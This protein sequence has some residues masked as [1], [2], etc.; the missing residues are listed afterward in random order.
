[1][2]KKASSGSLKLQKP[3]LYHIQLNYFKTLQDEGNI[4]D[5]HHLDNGTVFTRSH[6]SKATIMKMQRVLE[7]SLL[8]ELTVALKVLSDQKQTQISHFQILQLRHTENT[9]AVI[10]ASR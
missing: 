1:M 7:K 10:V 9:I 8:S 4:S 5:T 2:I 6:P 3:G